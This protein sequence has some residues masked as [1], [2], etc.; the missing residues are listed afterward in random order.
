[1]LYK[2]FRRRSFP[3]AQ[4]ESIPMT[5]DR[6]PLQT[7]SNL[8]LQR[9]AHWLASLALTPNQISLLSVVFAALAWSLLWT[10]PGWKGYLFAALFIQLRLLCN[11]VD[12][13]VAVE[14]GKASPTGK[15]YNEVPDRVADVFIIVGAGVACG[16][17]DLGWFAAVAAVVTAYIRALGASLGFDHDFQGPMAKPHRMAALT[18]GCVAAAAE[19][20]AGYPLPHGLMFALGVVA[21]GSVATC[22]TRLHL[23]SQQ[24]NRRG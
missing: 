4:H 20:L 14:G 1:M 11:V 15:L 22:G 23:L 18:L 16:L 10:H 9:F 8:L 21:A 19:S 12:G 13:L 7:R 3:Y 2:Q 5:S 24:L 6:R 17:A